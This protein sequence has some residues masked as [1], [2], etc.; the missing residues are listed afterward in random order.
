MLN[1]EF[2][3]AVSDQQNV[4]QRQLAQAPWRSRVPPKLAL[5]L[6]VRK[7]AWGPRNCFRFHP[8]LTRVQLGGLWAWGQLRLQGWLLGHPWAGAELAG[9]RVAGAACVAARVWAVWGEEPWLDLE[10]PF[11]CSGPNQTHLSP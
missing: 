5:W 6:R 7:Q 8:H 1:W 9:Q 10:L 4:R 2:L 3:H 11:L